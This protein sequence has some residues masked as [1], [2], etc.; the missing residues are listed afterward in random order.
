M[1]IFCCS[2]S[3]SQKPGFLQKSNWK[4]SCLSK[5]EELLWHLHRSNGNSQRD[6]HDQIAW[7]KSYQL[8]YITKWKNRLSP[9]KCMT[10]EK[11]WMKK[12]SSLSDLKYKPHL[13]TRFVRTNSPKCNCLLFIKLC[14]FGFL[15]IAFLKQTTSPFSSSVFQGKRFYFWW[16][17]LRY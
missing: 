5:R 12:S 17:E 9:L 14:L 10:L 11:E 1:A 8:C 16:E 6:H 15:F 3:P 13:L 7:K 4:E 2:W